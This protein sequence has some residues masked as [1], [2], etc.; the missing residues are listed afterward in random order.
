VTTIFRRSWPVYARKCA[1]FEGDFIACPNYD[2][3]YASSLGKSTDQLILD[4]KRT[5]RVPMG[6]GMYRPVTIMMHRDDAEALSK[7][8]PGMSVGAYGHL[9]SVQVVRILGPRE[10]EV[11]TPWIINET[12]L[13]AEISKLR[14]KLQR[15]RVSAALIEKKIKQQF[16]E[17]QK[18]VALQKSEGWR[19]K[20]RVSGFATS[21][22]ASGKR[23]TGPT[24]GLQLVIVKEEPPIGRHQRT[25]TYVAV[26][27][28]L[29]GRGISEEQFMQMLTAR[30]YTQEQF[31]ALVAQETEYQRE[32]AM[33]RVFAALERAR[34]A[35]AQREQA[36]AEARGEQ[37]EKSRDDPRFTPGGRRPGSGLPTQMENPD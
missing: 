33:A 27:M 10:M 18:L 5:E 36:I 1:P 6:T 21:R 16:G 22:I 17:R 26:P 30:D 11:S 2:R 9:D 29:F 8:L 14:S 4:S 32:G 24:T 25:S 13:N 23:W 28:A 31:A 34:V 3:R 37:D 20:I 12:D 15:Q 19:G 7:A 35:V